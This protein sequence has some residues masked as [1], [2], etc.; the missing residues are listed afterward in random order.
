MSFKKLKLSSPIIKACIEK[1]YKEPTDIQKE[2]IDILMRKRDLLLIAKTGTGKTA[3]FTLPML[4]DIFENQHKQTQLTK[5]VIAPTKEL[6]IQLQKTIQ[7]YSKHLELEIAVIY[8]GANI[9]QQ[10]KLLKSKINIVV[11]TTGRLVDLIK[12]NS[13]N[14]TKVDTMVLDEADTMLDLGFIKD[15]EYIVKNLPNLAQIVLSSATLGPNVKQLSN[16]L[17][18][19]PKII[20]VKSHDRINENLEQITYPV[21]HRDK[22]SM[23][24][25]LIGSKNFSSVIVFAK[26]KSL[27]DMIVKNLQLDGLKAG[28]IHGGKTPGFRKKVVEQFKEAKIKI[29]VATDVAA[30]GID[31]PNLPCVINFDMPFLI[32]DYLHRVGRTAR[33]GNDGLAISLIDEYDMPNLREIEKYLNMKLPRLELDGFKVDKKIHSLAKKKIVQAKEDPVVKKSTLGAFGN[34]KRPKKT[35]KPN[36]KFE[37]KE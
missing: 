6:A 23:L 5:L 7:E 12:Q 28:V 19:N 26:T 18:K 17:L 20:E 14:I 10:I 27:A 21:S 32:T 31:I 3:A 34:K 15:I 25:Y 16:E 35:K 8:G 29:L 1:G 22:L 30:R 24:S 37:A 36:Q 11:A 2:A 13:I 4:Q 33:A 9:N